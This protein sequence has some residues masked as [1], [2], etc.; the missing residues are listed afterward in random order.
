MTETSADP[1]SLDADEGFLESWRQQAA[2]LDADNPDVFFP[3]H[4]YGNTEKLERA[5]KAICAQCIVQPEC[6]DYAVRTNQPEGVWGGLN[7]D[8][9]R[10]YRK[11]WLANQRRNK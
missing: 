2:C 8:E 10:T 6:L 4:G 7:D 5:A 9:R 1:A 3:K 11:R